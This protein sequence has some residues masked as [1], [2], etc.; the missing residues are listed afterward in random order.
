MLEPS[1]P[2]ILNSSGCS[3]TA[4]EVDRRQA[5]ALSGD[6]VP[7]KNCL[8]RRHGIGMNVG[9]MV[10]AGRLRYSWRRLRRGERRVDAGGLRREREWFLFSKRNVA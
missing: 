2:F 10:F 5:Y 7:P 9:V 6:S 4:F 8:A 1:S 3:R